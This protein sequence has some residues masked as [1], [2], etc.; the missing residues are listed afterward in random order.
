MNV[1]DNGF[2]KDKLAFIDEAQAK[3]LDNVTI[4]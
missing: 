4:E 3:K 1:H 2:K